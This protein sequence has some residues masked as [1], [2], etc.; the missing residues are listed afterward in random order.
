MDNLDN[1]SI[2]C[3]FLNKKLEKAILDLWQV[4]ST[5][6]IYLRQDSADLSLLFFQQNLWSMVNKLDALKIAIEHLLFEIGYLQKREL[7]ESKD[8]K[9]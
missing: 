8:R 2:L 1:P 3:Q 5:I 4:Q 6:N 9:S 7:R